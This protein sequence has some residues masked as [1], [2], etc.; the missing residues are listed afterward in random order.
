[1]KLI[2]IFF[3]FNSRRLRFSSLRKKVNDGWSK[4][5]IISA[6]GMITFDGAAEKGID[7][8]RVAAV[9]EDYA[10]KILLSA[11]LGYQQ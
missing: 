7:G 1:M 5:Q 9:H 6:K 10:I 2:A 11:I 3:N 8:E 4:K